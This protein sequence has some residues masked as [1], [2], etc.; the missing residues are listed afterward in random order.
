MTLAFALFL[1]G[2]AIIAVAGVAVWRFHP[3][4]RPAARRGLARL[5]IIRET[6]RDQLGDHLAA[7]AIVLAGV[8]AAVAVSWPVGRFARRFQPNIDAPFLRWTE[9][10]VSAHGTWHHINAKLT[11][12]GNRPEIKPLCL[13]AAVIFA[14][15]WIHRGWWKPVLVIAAA[16]GLEKFGQA[17]LKLVV[18]RS[19]PD[20]PDFGAFPSGGVARLIT[21]YGIIFF[22]V[23]LTWPQITRGWRVAGWTVIAA[24]AF[25]EGYSR[26]YLLKHWGL[27]VVGGFVYGTVLLLGLM[28]AASCFGPRT[29]EPVP[30]DLDVP[31]QALPQPR[32]EPAHPG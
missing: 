13:I 17:A 23:L 16:F 21:V 19:K 5:T 9:R 20:L 22:L 1:I 27:D 32:R 10:H 31:G 15:L 3:T 25:T 30:L 2:I 28:A 26:I 8:A 12:M 6:C 24:L 4:G 29:R 14:V 7:L 18:D 11:L